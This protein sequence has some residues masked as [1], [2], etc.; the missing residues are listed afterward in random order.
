MWS[1]LAGENLSDKPLLQI[2]KDNIAMN[3]KLHWKPARDLRK[4]FFSPAMYLL[5]AMF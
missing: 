5:T 3:I 2:E 1:Q 4:S